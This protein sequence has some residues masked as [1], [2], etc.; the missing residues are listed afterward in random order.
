MQAAFGGLKSNNAAPHRMESTETQYIPP[1]YESDPS[2]T[3]D[4]TDMNDWKPQ[5]MEIYLL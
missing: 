5:E 2:Y 1:Y 3:Y 4:E